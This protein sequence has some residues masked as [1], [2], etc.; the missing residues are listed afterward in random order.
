MFFDDKHFRTLYFQPRTLTAGFHVQF[1]G[2]VACIAFRTT[3]L[4]VGTTFVDFDTRCLA[5]A[6][7]AFDTRCLAVA[8]TFV[9]VET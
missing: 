5:V 3:R 7:V 6:T 2:E 9:A 1:D 4:A 8:T